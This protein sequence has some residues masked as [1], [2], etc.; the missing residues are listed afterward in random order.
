MFQ[1][2]LIRQSI[3]KSIRAVLQDRCSTNTVSALNASSSLSDLTWKT[4]FL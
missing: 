4:K 3:I 1:D 2:E